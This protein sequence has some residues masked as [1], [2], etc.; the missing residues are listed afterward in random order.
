MEEDNS[1]P[2]QSRTSIASSLADNASEDNESLDGSSH[3]MGLSE[4]SR[5][6]Y[7]HHSSVTIEPDEDE[8]GNPTQDEQTTNG[9]SSIP[10]ITVPG[11]GDGISTASLAGSLAAPE[12][13][14]DKPSEREMDSAQSR[15]QEPA[16]TG[17]DWDQTGDKYLLANSLLSEV[18]AQVVYALLDEY[19]QQL[20]VL[21]KIIAAPYIKDYVD[22]KETLRQRFRREEDEPLKI[23][24]NRGDHIVPANPSLVKIQQ[25]RAYLSKVLDRLMKELRR[26]NSYVPLIEAVEAE[27]IRRQEFVLIEEDAIANS[28]HIAELRKEIRQLKVSMVEEIRDRDETI[29]EL[30]DELQEVLARTGM[31]MRYT[32]ASMQA[33]LVTS[34][35]Q[36]ET[37]R[38]AKRQEAEHARVMCD[39]E[40]RVN[41]EIES[42]LRDSLDELN[43]T[44]D[45]RLT[46]F[47]VDTD[48][49]ERELSNLKYQKQQNFQALCEVKDRFAEY[50]RVIEEDDEELREE[51]ERLQEEA[52]RVH[53]ATVIQAYWKGYAERKKFKKKL[54]K[55]KKAAK[56]AKKDAKKKK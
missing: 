11:K 52:R 36:L 18:D 15:T 38:M 27:G 9:L 43:E 56:K 2:A 22:E 55:A 33:R 32:Q 19:N 35:G 45:Q 1:S 21:G 51:E 49:K 3:V 47:D 31:E 42:Q 29:L 24:S 37:R 46:K 4:E 8:D 16:L 28:Q 14:A 23:R 50:T 13:V 39:Y 12:S 7:S 53:A 48:A 40:T 20:E 44:L 6:F 17:N 30:K 41:T 54:K 10:N 25:D 34:D 26:E 5:Q